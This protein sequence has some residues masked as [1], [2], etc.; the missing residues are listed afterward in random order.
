MSDCQMTGIELLTLAG[1]YQV[2][3]GGLVKP[4]SSW[5]QHAAGKVLIMIDG[6]DEVAGFATR[7]KDCPIISDLTQKAHPIDLCLN[8]LR[9]NLLPGVT[10]ISAS[11][12]FAGLDALQFDKKFEILGRTESCIKEFVER[13]HPS[14]FADIM[15]VLTNSPLLMS[16]CSI[17]FYC[18][19]ISRLLAAGVIFPREDLQTYTRLMAFLIVQCVERKLPEWS[20]LIQVST[21]FRKLSHMAYMGVFERQLKGEM[22]KLV[23]NDRDISQAELTPPDLRSIQNAGLLNFQKIK[24][25]LRLSVTAEFFHLSVQEMLASAYFLPQLPLAGNVLKQLFSGG[26]FNMA[27]LYLF[28]LQYDTGSEWINDIRHSVSPSGDGP[29]AEQQMDDFLQ[30]LC[31]QCGKQPGFSSQL[32]LCQLLY[33]GQMEDKAK[34]VVK[35]IVPDGE[36]TIEDTQL[37]LIDLMAVWFMCKY[38]DAITRI[39]ITH[40]GLTETLLRFMT[41]SLLKDN[42]EKR[43]VLDLRGNNLGDGGAEAV[44]E[45][46]KQ[47]NT[48]HTLNLHYNQIGDDGAAAIAAALQTNT[49]LHTLRVGA[50]QIGDVGAAAI[51]AALQANTSLHTLDVAGNHIGDAGAAAIAAALQTNTSLHTLWSN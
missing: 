6:L 8:I 19:L 9:G 4:L 35:Q 3:E 22:S 29:G 14:K 45:W 42:A 28:G 51:A 47:N 30:T 44:A 31:Q 23:F 7:L 17:T 32:Q 40:C 27:L 18:A 10:V 20:F 2:A 26:Q 50:N 41:S 46:L 36:L 12:P 5:L 13:K 49:S 33:E 25:G 1:L 43:L 39:S 11:R 16:V 48:L 38:A 34:S 21:Y 15:A 24:V 37:T